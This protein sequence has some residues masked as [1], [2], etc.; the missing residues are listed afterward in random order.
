MLEIFLVVVQLQC[1]ALY[2][3][4]FAFAYFRDKVC[5]ITMEVKGTMNICFLFKVVYRLGVIST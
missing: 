3:A 4:L 2:I 1:E 5:Y